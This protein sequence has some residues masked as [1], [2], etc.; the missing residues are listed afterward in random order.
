MKFFSKV[1]SSFQNEL[2]DCDRN[3]LIVCTATHKTK[4]MYFFLVQTD[5][6]D[7]FKVTLE[8]E[9]DIVSQIFYSVVLLLK[10]KNVLKNLIR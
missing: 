1:Y 10:K 6:G 4:L 5:Q 7:V 3:V 9:H 2:D 8:S